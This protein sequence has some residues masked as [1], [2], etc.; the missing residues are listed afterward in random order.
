VLTIPKS[1]VIPATIAGLPPAQDLEQCRVG[2]MPNADT[3]EG[4]E[5]PLE[6][7]LVIIGEDF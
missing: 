3:F 5:L 6:V 7:R 1:S 2:I 4:R